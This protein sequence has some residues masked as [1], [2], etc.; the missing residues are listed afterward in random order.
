MSLPQSIPPFPFAFKPKVANRKRAVSLATANKAESIEIS[1][2]PV[3][4]AIQVY[5]TGTYTTPASASGTIRK[6]NPAEQLKQIIL[7]ANGNDILKDLSGLHAYLLHLWRQRRTPRVDGI[8]AAEAAAN[9]T[10]TAFFLNT[11]L[12]LTEPSQFGLL[13][14]AFLQSLHLDITPA[15]L[16]GS[17]I[18]DSPAAGTTVTALAA[19]INL[20]TVALREKPRH[21]F[22]SLVEKQLTSTI[23]AADGKHR[24]RLQNGGILN[25]LLLCAYAGSAKNL[26]DA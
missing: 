23:A 4:H 9:S 17:A 13:C 6:L 8:S 25:K 14:T 15:A 21:G 1:R 22:G 11:M 18:V 2:G 20:E 12:H 5:Q 26:S 3:L 24:I 16:N 7:R 19:D 10:A